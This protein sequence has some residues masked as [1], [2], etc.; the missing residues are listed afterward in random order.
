MSDPI[1]QLIDSLLQER[2]K[3]HRGRVQRYKA[4][5]AELKKEREAHEKKQLE[6]MRSAGIK[7]EVIEKQQKEDSRELK[8]YLEKTL[9][10]L[11]SRPSMRL[12]DTKQAAILG[13]GFGGFGQIVPPYAGVFYPPDGTE[14]LPV[15]PSQIKIKDSDQGSGTGWWA[16]GGPPDP[17]VEVIFGFTPEN[18]DNYS[19]TASFAFHG[20][21]VLKANDGWLTHKDASVFLDFSLDAFQ[22]VDLGPKSFPKPIDKDGDNIKVFDNFDQVLTFSDTRDFRAGEPVVVT[23]RITLDASASG[24]GSVAEINFAD[25]DANYIQPQYLWVS[26]SLG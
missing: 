19:F 12:K 11:I 17:S 22:F 3:D 14:V 7:L 16:T 8:S 15:D 18:S 13:V 26:P 5:N 21:Y 25:G 4:G 6:Y 10:P 9:P 24:S 2:A 23:A 20:F 1:E